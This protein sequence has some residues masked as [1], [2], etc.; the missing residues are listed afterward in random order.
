M[1]FPKN[2]QKKGPVFSPKEVQNFHQHF[3]AFF[4][5]KKAPAATPPAEKNGLWPIKWLQ[6]S[7]K[8]SQKNV[9]KGSKK[10]S[11]NGSRYSLSS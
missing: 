3:G 1:V 8:R 4:L 6:K 9:K 10:V 7:K 2:G 5:K 11:K